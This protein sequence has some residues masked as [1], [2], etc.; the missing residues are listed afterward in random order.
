[1]MLGTPRGTGRALKAGFRIG[2]QV[3]EA[4]STLKR[5]AGIAPAL[6]P[7]PHPPHS[8]LASETSSVTASPPKPTLEGIR[9]CPASPAPLCNPNFHFLTNQILPPPVP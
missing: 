5:R 6:L 2:L 8:Q 4:N 3:A 7:P 1:M 9:C